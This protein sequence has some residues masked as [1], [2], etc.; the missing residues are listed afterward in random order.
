MAHRG[1]GPVVSTNQENPGTP[2]LPGLP[3]APTSFQ[4][5][6]T[7]GTVTI[8]STSASY[9]QPLAPGSSLQVGGST[10]PIGSGTYASLKT[11]VGGARVSEADTRLSTSVT[12]PAR[13]GTVAGEV[14]LPTGGGD[15][16]AVVSYRRGGFTGTAS[17]HDSTVDYTAGI[18]ENIDAHTTVEGILRY[19]GDTDVISGALKVGRTVG[20]KGNG[21]ISASIE[22]TPEERQATAGIQFTLRR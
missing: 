14:T 10:N 16:R 3:P 1:R 15:P 19:A 5:P 11:P 13:M 22:G 9:T 4:V 8:G 6:A 7:G 20:P 21:Q 17:A 2:P 18:K 12:L